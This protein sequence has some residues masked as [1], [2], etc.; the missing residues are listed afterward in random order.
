MTF[1]ELIGA[2]MRRIREQAGR[3]QEDIAAAAKAHGLTWGRSSVANLEAGRGRLSGVE[4]YLLPSILSLATGAKVRV[5]A[6]FMSADDPLVEL[7][8]TLSLPAGLLAS[9]RPGVVP[10]L[11]DLPAPDLDIDEATMKAARVL[12]LTP[13]QVGQFADELWGRR[14]SE[15][16]D[17]RAAARTPAGADARSVAAIKGGVTRELITEIRAHLRAIEEAVA[18]QDA[19]DRLARGLE[20]HA[21]VVAAVR[22]Q[23]ASLRERLEQMEDTKGADRVDH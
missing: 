18:A 9:P 21:V 13:G 7:T 10:P 6:L 20:A 3:L 23:R 14:L 4:T 11:A 2:N 19:K 22:Q 15:V 17:E 5:A 16:R 12:R 8:P 1:E